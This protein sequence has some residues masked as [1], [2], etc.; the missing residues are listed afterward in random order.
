MAGRG[1]DDAIRA[2]AYYIWE[3]EGRPEGR[4]LDHWAR[5]VIETHGGEP[6]PFDEEEKVLANLPANLPA[7]LTKDVQGE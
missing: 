6:D 7:L 3:R 1:E 2:A 5:A 4:A